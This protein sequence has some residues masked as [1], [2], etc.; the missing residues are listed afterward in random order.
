MYVCT[1]V[2]YTERTY[3]RRILESK[4]LGSCACSPSHQ[5]GEDCNISRERRFYAL[6]IAT[7]LDVDDQVSGCVHNFFVHSIF[8]GSRV[9]CVLCGNSVVEQLCISGCRAERTPRITNIQ[10]FQT[11][12]N[13]IGSQ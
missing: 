1:S 5:T 7:T 9:E 6:G 13:V 2:L 12:Q 3:G 8:S 11:A 4:V 10:N